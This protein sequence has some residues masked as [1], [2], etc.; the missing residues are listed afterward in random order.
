[1]QLRASERS[2]DQ[3]LACPRAQDSAA[4]PHVP[5]ASTLGHV[6]IMGHKRLPLPPVGSL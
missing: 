1:M 5:I 6:T 3:E 2:M 4:W